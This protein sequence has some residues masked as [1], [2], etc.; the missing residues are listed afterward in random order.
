[1]SYP[2]HYEEIKTYSTHADSDQLRDN[3]PARGLIA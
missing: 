1:M 3:R 2:L